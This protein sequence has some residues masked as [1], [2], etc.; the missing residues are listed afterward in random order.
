MAHGP[1]CPFF[2]VLAAGV[3]VVVG[4]MFCVGKTYHGK[5]GE[6]L[7]MTWDNSMRIDL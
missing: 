5:T 1:S 7:E 4:V 2:L 6:W 3:H